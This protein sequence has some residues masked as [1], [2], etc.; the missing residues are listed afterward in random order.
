[1]GEERVR[2]YTKREKEG[3]GQTKKEIKPLVVL[4]EQF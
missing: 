3:E 2:S 1:M 4:S